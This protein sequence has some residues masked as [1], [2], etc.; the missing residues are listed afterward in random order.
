MLTIITLPRLCIAPKYAVLCLVVVS[1]NLQPSLIHC[2]STFLK[3]RFYIISSGISCAA[4]DPLCRPQTAYIKGLFFD[5]P[6]QHIDPMSRLSESG[7][8]EFVRPQQ[9]DIYYLPVCA[10]VPAALR[11]RRF[12]YYVYRSALCITPS[13]PRFSRETDCVTL[14]RTTPATRR[15]SSETIIGVG[16]RACGA[17]VRVSRRRRR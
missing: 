7:N 1:T 6:A 17:L 9:V 12:D 16:T 13:R 11:L 10:F 4:L 5:A 8:H 14:S 2:P 15:S 3:L